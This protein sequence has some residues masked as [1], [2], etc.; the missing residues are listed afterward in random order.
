MVAR[1][2]GGVGVLE[3][4]QRGAS[5]TARTGKVR[6]GGAGRAAPALRAHLDVPRQAARNPR[7]SGASACT[8][9]FQVGR[10]AHRLAATVSAGR[11]R[12]QP[13]RRRPALSERSQ[14]GRVRVRSWLGPGLRALRRRY[15]CKLQVACR[16]RRCR[17]APVRAARR[18]LRERVPRHDRH[19]G[20]DHRDNRVSSVHATYCTE[21]DWKRFGEHGWLL[22]TGPAVSLAQQRLRLL[23]RFLRR[24]GLTQAQGDPQGA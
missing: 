21:A 5:T 10:P 19:A 14:P 15:F 16:S 6:R 13:A 23:R 1:D 7:R 18:L 2:S 22:P 20:Q 3:T 11:A 4:K 24:A 17:P 12:W 8:A 9:Q